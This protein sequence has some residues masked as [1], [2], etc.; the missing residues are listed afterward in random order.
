MKK[1]N[2]KTP[3]I[4]LL[5]PD[6]FPMMDYKNHPDFIKGKEVL[7]GVSKLM[8]ELPEGWTLKI[9]DSKDLDAS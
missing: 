6:D 9:D 4:F 2:V 1:S 7:L 3:T 5:L 8:K